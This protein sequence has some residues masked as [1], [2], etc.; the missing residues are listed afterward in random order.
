MFEVDNRMYFVDIEDVLEDL[1]ISVVTVTGDNLMCCC[2]IH[3]ERN[4]SFGVHRLSG[5]YQCFSCGAKGN[6]L[7]L[8]SEVLR[9][10]YNDA[11]KYLNKFQQDNR[12]VPN[13]TIPGAKGPVSITIPFDKQ[14]NVYSYLGNRNITRE[15]ID[16]FDI[17]SEGDDVVF[18]IKAKKGTVIGYQRRSMVAKRFKFMPGF[19]MKSNVYGLDIL[20]RYGNPEEPVIITESIIDCLT[21]WSY[22]YQAVAVFSA[23]VTNEHI[24]K[25]AQTPFRIFMDGLDRDVAGR[26]GWDKAKLLLISKGLRPITMQDHKGK[27]INDLSLG[28]FEEWKNS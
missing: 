16:R 23:Y 7:N 3:G 20:V 9:I 14:E 26:L 28:E 25:L 17:F 8:I 12:S 13:I 21:V 1:G 11:A 4:P 27:D 19:D 2:P 24:K 6:T 22:G 10:S 5:I 15:I 18:P